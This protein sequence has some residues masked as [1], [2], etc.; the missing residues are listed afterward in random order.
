VR[1]E[2]HHVDAGQRRAQRLGA[3]DEALHHFD[4]WGQRGLRRV[5]REGAHI[6]GAEC[7]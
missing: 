1:R 2:I 5:D 6:G 7:Q 3:A 4:A